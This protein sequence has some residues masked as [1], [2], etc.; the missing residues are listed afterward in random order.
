MTSNG[1]LPVDYIPRSKEEVL[2]EIFQIRARQGLESGDRHEMVDV[3]CAFAPS[4]AIT[5]ATTMT[6]VVPTDMWHIKYALCVEADLQ[7][8]W[9]KL[10]KES[11]DGTLLESIRKWKYVHNRFEREK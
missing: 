8:E 11:I 4:R 5:L 3:L 10:E 2:L 7:K 9:K 1:F 6:G